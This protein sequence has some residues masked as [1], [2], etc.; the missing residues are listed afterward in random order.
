M[1]QRTESVL[2]GLMVAAA[3]AV[4]TAALHREFWANK[5][6]H[7]ADAVTSRFIPD[8]E[9]LLQHGSLIGLPTAKVKIIEFADYECPFCREFQESF[10]AAKRKFGDDV[11]LTFIDFPLRGHRFALPAARA[12]ACAGRQEKFREIHDLLFEKQDSLGLKSWASFAK[13]ASVDDSSSFARC[14]MDSA[15]LPQVRGGL[16]TGTRLEV[17][18]TPTILINGWRYSHPIYGDSL[19][20]EIARHAKRGAA[21]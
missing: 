4:A 10:L 1:K 19:V 17:H 21:N 7:S 6:P 13:E 5:T 3:L 12:A 9:E 11:S 15:E 14:M 20:S 8:W 2:T 16:A 18:G